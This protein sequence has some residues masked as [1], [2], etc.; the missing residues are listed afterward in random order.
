[1]NKNEC[2]F[3]DD[4]AAIEYQFPYIAISKLAEQESWRKEI[5]R[6]IY[7]IHK[8]WAT[9]LGSVFRGAVLGS[10]LHGNQNIMDFYYKK[11]NFAS[12]IILDPFMGS[13]TSLGEAVKLGAKAIGCDINPISTFIVNQSFENVSEEE[14]EKYFSI[15]ELNIKGKIQS[16]YIT[17]DPE[18]GEE[19]PV[20]YFFWVKMLE[21]PNGEI[22]PLFSDYIFAKN[23]YPKKKPMVQIICFKCWS[24]FQNRYD[25]VEVICPH[26]GNTFNP[27]IGRAT[28]QN[29]I[30]SDGK[31]YKIKELVKSHKKPLNHKMYAILALRNNGEKIYLKPS[32]FDCDLYQKASKDLQDK[33]ITIP[34]LKVRSGHNTD[35]ARGYNYYYWKDF[36][37]DRQLLCL[38]LLLE[39][40]MQIKKMDVQEQFLCL[41]SSILEF[42]NLF[43]SFKGEGTGAVRHLFYN[44]I[45]KPEKTPIENSIW[46]TDKSSG[47]F[48]TLFKSRLLK[49]KAYLKSPFEIKFVCD[50]FGATAS[51]E[52]FVASEPIVT[53]KVDSWHDFLSKEKAIYILNGDSA[54][55][56][57]PNASVDAVVTDPPYFDFV[58][59]S[60]LSDF[61]FAWLAPVLSKRYGYFN[62]S[63]CA[64][65]AEVQHKDPLIFSK[66]L[67]NVFLECR[68][69]LKD[70]GILIFSFHHSRPE[71]WAAIYQSIF[72]SGFRLVNFYPVY[73]EFKGATPKYASNSPISI[74]ILLVCKKNTSLNNNSVNFIHNYS[75]QFINEF[76]ANGFILSENDIFVIKSA[77][78]LLKLNGKNLSYD[79]TCNYLESSLLM[80]KQN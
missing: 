78:C 7:H 46:G 3:T 17:R 28:G 12:K 70:N 77:T 76:L 11:N 56:D 66:L 16:Y 60:E 52:K 1:M 18:T 59:Y 54:K 47:T 33:N 79:D 26:C 44:H 71:G 49:A 36:F 65:D 68:R 19:I 74:D 10:L 39:T 53:H 30:C 61:F 73:A 4:S 8:W 2:Y 27:Q 63:N 58:H 34:L 42:N 72:H 40:V 51:T 69:V 21:C 31:T 29:V 48:C 22:V 41:F 57:I 80:N 62:N 5:N 23:A 6:P 15:I 35:Q 14:L 20:L 55:I 50:M 25:A 9:R 32:K 64:H 45:L 43:C 37:N 13:G 38:N 67:C 24:I 75:E